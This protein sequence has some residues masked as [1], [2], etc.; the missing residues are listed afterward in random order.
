MS[1][2]PSEINSNVQIYCSRNPTLWGQNVP[3]KMAI[4]EI[5]DLKQLKT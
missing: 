2:D 4:P 5:F 1:H 3:T